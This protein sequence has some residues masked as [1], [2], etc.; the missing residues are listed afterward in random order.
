MKQNWFYLISFLLFSCSYEQR[1]NCDC[2]VDQT[3]LMVYSTL[4]SEIILPEIDSIPSYDTLNNEYHFIKN[5]KRRNFLLVDSTRT[6]QGNKLKIN[7][8][9][10]LEKDFINKNM[11]SCRL[12]IKSL[13]SSRFYP[14]SNDDRNK[15]FNKKKQPYQGFKQLYKDYKDV[16]GII[17]L[18]MIGY[19]SMKNRAL[20]EISFHIGP[21]NAFGSLVELRLFDNKWKIENVYNEWIS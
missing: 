6:Y 5:I 11:H 7:V 10:I 3:D 2:N 19:N 9:S 13:Q 21:L 18:S 15:Y 4:I 16:S 1:E 20:V 14:F 17:E 12:C 8:D